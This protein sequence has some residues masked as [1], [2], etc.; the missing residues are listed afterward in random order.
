MSQEPRVAK[1]PSKRGVATHVSGGS[2]QGIGAAHYVRIENFTVHNAASTESAETSALPHDHGTAPCPY[3]GLAY[4]GPSDRGHFFGRDAVVTRL[5]SRVA[6]HPFTALIGPSGS[7]KSSVVL[8]GLAPHLDD[9][10]TWCFTYFRVGKEVDQNP[11]RALS[12]ALVPL[13]RGGDIVDQLREIENLAAG[14]QDGITL[15]NVLS[16]CVTR[17]EGKRVLV[18]ADQFE[19]LFTR[20]RFIDDNL[21]DRFI[22]CLLDAFQTRPDGALPQASLILTMRADFFGSALRYRRLADT[23]Q[24]NVEN[25][26]PMTREELWDAIEKPALPLKFEGGLISTLVND[27]VRRPGSLPLLQFAL[28]EM[29]ER[30]HVNGLTRISY[31]AIGGIEGAL[32]KRAESIYLQMTTNDSV[33]DVKSA[34]RQLFTRLVT[35]GEGA[36]DTRRVADRTELGASSWDLAQQLAGEANRLIVT[37]SE[38]GNRETA[39]LVH[40]ALIRG[41]PRL[42]DW[43]NSDRAFL[44]WLSQLKPRIED[45][46]TDRNDE[47]TLLRGGPLATAQDWVSRK[48]PEISGNEKAYV[49]ASIT[50]FEAAEA[51]DAKTRE[52]EAVRQRLEAQTAQHTAEREVRLRSEAERERD[53][54][55]SARG[56]L[57]VA[58]GAAVMLLIAVAVAAVLLNR[59]RL[60]AADATAEA[61]RQAGNANRARDVATQQKNLA[62]FASTAMKALSGTASEESLRLSTEAASAVT[63]TSPVDQIQ[64]YLDFARHFDLAWMPPQ[65]KLALR[66]IDDLIPTL[67]EDA[68]LRSTVNRLSVYKDELDGD[69]EFTNSSEPGRS[70]AAYQKALT[71]VSSS[72]ATVGDR[73]RILAKL[74]KVRE[75]NGDNNGAEA[76]LSDAESLS[77]RPGAIASEL[78]LALLQ[79][80]R[81]KILA[82]HGDLHSAIDRMTTAVAALRAAEAQNAASAE[83]KVR[84]GGALQRLADL[85]RGSGDRVRAIESYKLALRQFQKVVQADP[86]C[87]AALGGIDTVRHSLRLLGAADEVDI[88]AEKEDRAISNA[89]QHAF[90]TGIGP[91]RFGM[92]PHEVNLLLLQPFNELSFAHLPPGGEFRWTNAVYFWKYFREVPGLSEITAVSPCLTRNGYASFVFH[93]GRLF[94]IDIRAFRRGDPACPPTANSIDDFAHRY[95]LVAFG[96]REERRLRYET[97]TVGINAQT[98]PEVLTIDVFQR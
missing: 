74:A 11:Y 41:W 14:L 95:G 63:S 89:I 17:N 75:Y 25:L 71:L 21:A 98:D 24:D 60:A 45:W 15:T 65:G 8:A 44:R 90:G 38:S 52:D 57:R 47:G 20:S 32:A 48:G 70:P 6:N 43:V 27:V 67:R 22:D 58:L 91:Y 80:V 18:I 26:G 54:A 34:F 37:D 93:E 19:E 92:T 82:A 62:V 85:E 88:Q 49:S 78:D 59:E 46:N 16:E 84:L 68:G 66:N 39:E 72:D 83:A 29:W 73:I 50:A 10:L 55:K 64:T 69:L 30:R 35:L 33:I 2:I 7:G 87:F 76:A 79:D 86:S 77:A 36:E 28:R 94:R 12:R 23:L 9:S 96:S 3:P 56:N 97:P 4:F 42:V 1:V 81:A 31:D 51:R 5:A 53:A 61:Q 13:F 40:E